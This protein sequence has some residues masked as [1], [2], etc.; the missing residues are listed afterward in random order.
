MFDLVE[1]EP[2]ALDLFVAD[3]ASAIRRVDA[4]GPV[5]TSATTGRSYQP[6]IGPHPETEVV[7]LV[8]QSLASTDPHRYGDLSLNV[9]YP[10]ISR[11][12]CDLVIEGRSGLAIEVKMLRLMGDNGKAND[13]MLM[14]ILSPYPSHRSALTDC[15]KLGD[16]DFSERRAVLIYGFD[17]PKW[18][19]DPAIEAFETLAR[20]QIAIG[21]RC[22]ASF[23]G[24]LHP[25]HR[26][27]RV[28]AWEILG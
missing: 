1:L 28:F 17:Y 10:G 5:W 15:L 23:D 2:V 27:G 20:V 8:A 4:D 13:N 6:G 25:I 26:Q 24:L 16:S 18:P 22:E 3:V 21:D 12:K 14:H 11:Q 19:L 9:P 7:R